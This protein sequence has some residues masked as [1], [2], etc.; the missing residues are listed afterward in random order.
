MSFGGKHKMSKPNID[1]KCSEKKNNKFLSYAAIF[2]MPIEGIFFFG[3]AVGWPNLAEILKAQGV[4]ANVCETET[5]NTTMVN[6]PTRDEFFTAVGTVGSIT[7][8]SMVFPLGLIFDRYGSF[9]T[10]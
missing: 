2:T 6:C 7:M 8:N 9:I 4:Y 3:I 10:R 5:K 1:G